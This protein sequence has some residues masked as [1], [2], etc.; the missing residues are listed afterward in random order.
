MTRASIERAGEP[1]FTYKQVE[2]VLVDLFD[3][4]LPKRPA[5]I[6]RLKQLQRL[7][8]PQGTRT[9]RGGKVKY[10]YWQLMEIVLYFDL[11]DCGVHPSVLTEHFGRRS[12]FAIGGIGE[13]VEM[14]AAI[15]G[16]GNYFV[17]R[18]RTLQFM[19][20][21]NPDRIEMRV[22]DGDFWTCSAERLPALISDVPSIAIDLA[23]R[24][25]RLK[26]AVARQVPA[27]AGIPAFPPT[28]PRPGKV[29]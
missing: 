14:A 10:A 15:P 22:T 16:Q 23:E 7:G 25:R 8:L 2:S 20:S 11:I 27:Y 17:P 9:G 24:L 1:A 6:A 19:R 3:I 4:S 5:F 21:E 13:N 12:F 26:L 28:P 18:F 29:G